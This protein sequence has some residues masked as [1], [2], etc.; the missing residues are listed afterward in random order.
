MSRFGIQHVKTAVRTPRANGQ[1]ER[2]NRTILSAIRCSTKDAKEW[3]TTL[4]NIQWSMN[5]QNNSTT[6]ISPNELVFNFDLRCV[7]ENRLV[8][9]VNDE[10]TPEDTD[11]Q[12]KQQKAIENIDTERQKWKQRYDRA[13]QRPT[14]YNEGQLVVIDYIPSA[15]GDTHKLDPK[16]R[17]P[18]LVT[19]QLAHDRYVVEDLP[20]APRTQRHYCNIV[21]SDHMKPWC[22]L[23]P[24][25]EYDE[26]DASAVSDDE[27]S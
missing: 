8:Q 19:K 10:M 16:F 7:S 12:E 21:S 5:S 20:D 17:G 6:K 22:L 2:V 15:T 24:D 18:Y 27:T 26:D 3:D 23:S 11:N 4:S 14:V 25:L 9:A 13:H 1:A